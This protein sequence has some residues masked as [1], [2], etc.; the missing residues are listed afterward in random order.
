MPRMGGSSR[1]LELPGSSAPQANLCPTS[2]ASS[3]ARLGGSAPA[4]AVDQD[5]RR[6]S[7][8]WY[9]EDSAFEW[10]DELPSSS[11]SAWSSPQAGNAEPAMDDMAASPE[12][13]RLRDQQRRLNEI[14]KIER[15]FVAGQSLSPVQ[16]V[17]LEFKEEAVTE[18]IRAQQAVF[19][20]GKSTR[21]GSVAS[22]DE[23]EV[24]SRSGTTRSSS[25]SGHETAQALPNRMVLPIAAMPVAVPPPAEVGRQVSSPESAGS[26]SKRKAKGQS[27]E[28]HVS[29]I[30]EAQMRAE[31]RFASE[32][33]NF[34]QDDLAQLQAARRRR[35][36]GEKTSGAA[37]GQGISDD[38]ASFDAARCEHLTQCLESGR[39]ARGEAVAAIRGLVSG[40]SFQPSGC[41]LVQ[42]AL[43]TLD[44]Q[45]AA[46]LVTELHGQ[47]RE[48][49][50]SPHANYVI[51]KIIEAL[52]CAQSS[53]ISEE[54]MGMGAMVA[55]H[56]YGC[57]ILC[58]LLE[59]CTTEQGTEKLVT[60]VLDDAAGLSRHS[61]GHHVIQ[62]ILEHGSTKQQEQIVEGLM[63]DLPRNARNRNASYV[64]ERV[65]MHTD[66]EIQRTLLGKLLDLG[67]EMWSLL[68]RSYLGSHVLKSVMR[69]PSDI[70]PQAMGDIRL[71]TGKLHGTR[72][73]KQ[74]LKDLGMINSAVGAAC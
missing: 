6:K 16:K 61:F 33:Q 59:H 72:H 45:T 39:E 10:A 24:Q 30:E 17:Q 12:S 18:V 54:L 73:G 42:H 11:V 64:L 66:E 67:P 2:T 51:Q 38:L 32:V 43:Q 49:F 65:F 41:R 19:D 62:C 57:R 69:F 63:E 68:T 1:F 20:A 55:R 60:E 44:V 3:M 26:A 22:Q 37:S 74:L 14:M 70:L 29:M 5:L 34:S 58:R 31:A 52:P 4:R 15:L 40:L 56:R 23:M 50:Q 71:A 27:S 53:F 36:R 28:Q 8:S 35:R 48:A 21:T 47:V 25:P 46:E 7:F 13:R 9:N